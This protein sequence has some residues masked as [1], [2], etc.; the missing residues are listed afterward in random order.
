MDVTWVQ[1]QF[2]Y[3][4]ICIDWLII[5]TVEAVDFLFVRLEDRVESVYVVT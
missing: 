1:D 3:Q 4:P 2:N 5:R